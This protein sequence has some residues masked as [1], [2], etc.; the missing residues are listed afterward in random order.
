MTVNDI[1]QVLQLNKGKTIKQVLNINNAL[2]DFFNTEKNIGYDFSKDSLI[3]DKLI[4]IFNEYASNID[5]N[6][7]GI[8]ADKDLPF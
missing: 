5:Q 3:N 2:Q 8:V 4:R 1:K 7:R 6:M